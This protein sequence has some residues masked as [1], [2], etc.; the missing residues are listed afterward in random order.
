VT[1]PP[2]STDRERLVL[3][4]FIAVSVLA[5]GNA[6][7]VRFSNR[8]LDPLWGAGLRFSLAAIVLLAIMAMLRLRFPRG[9]ALTGALLFGLLNFAG[10]FALAYYA[11]LH[12]HAGFGQILLA[13][14][15][16]LTLLLA[17]LQRQERLRLAAVVGTLLALAGVALMSR[18]P[19]QEEVPLLAVLAAIG[20]ALCFAEAAV[21]VRRFPTI[22]PVTMNAVAMAT[23]AAV[24]LAG[25]LIV[26]ERIQLPQRAAT[27]VALGYL[28]AVGSVVVF[29]LYLFV[30]RYWTASRAAYTFVLIPVVTVLLSA[31]LDDEPIRMG[32]V[33]GGLLVLAGVYIG[34]LRPAEQPSAQPAASKGS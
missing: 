12:V 17:V 4:A 32:L 16:L 5:G 30:L 8:E 24:L 1:T 2:S 7:G 22:H 26:G 21:L 23:G 10:A 28:V 33:L 20:G 15:P 9:R 18:A 13:L 27:W 25:S 14:V 19:L 3:A 29:V 11:L 31:W 6:V 34:A